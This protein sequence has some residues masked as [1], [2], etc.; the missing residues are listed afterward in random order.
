MTTLP[1][2]ASRPY[3]FDP[4]AEE[5]R[6]RR[7]MLTVAEQKTAETEVK[8]TAA[9]AAADE[10]AKAAAAAPED[11]AAADVAAKREEAAIALEKDLETQTG[12]VAS[13]RDAIPL[14]DADAAKR[15]LR[16]VYLLRV[17]NFI[18]NSQFEQ[19][20]FD[21]PP[22]PSD[23]KM[24]QAMKAVV[25]ASGSEYGVTATDDDFKALDAAFRASGGGSVPKD[26]VGVFEDLFARLAET[27][28]VRKV[29]KQ[30]RAHKSG[31]Q[32]LRLGLYVAGVEGLPD[33][34]QFRVVDGEATLDSLALIPP[35]D[36]EMILNKVEELGTTRGREGNS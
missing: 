31:L 21:V 34:D 9:R 29:L 24:F 11:Q 27:P 3:R 8:A 16:P 14:V 25:L 6:R 17:P 35:A 36:I 20:V 12:L 22:S 23:R 26:V 7:E 19:S 28:E 13:L 18:L 32:R 1:I 2:S 33:A 10:A 4:I 30:R 5:V 15:T